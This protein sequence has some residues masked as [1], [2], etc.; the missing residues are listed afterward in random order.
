MEER[1]PSRRGLGRSE[2]WRSTR[3]WRTPS[4]CTLQQLGADRGG[5]HGPIGRLVRRGTTTRTDGTVDGP[6]EPHFLLQLGRGGEIP[7]PATAVWA[8]ADAQAANRAARCAGSGSRRGRAGARAQRV[9]RRLRLRGARGASPRRYLGE[10]ARET[11]RPGGIPAARRLASAR[12]CWGPV[13]FSTH[14]RCDPSVY[15][16]RRVNSILSSGASV[17]RETISTTPVAT[18]AVCERQRRQRARTCSGMSPRCRGWHSEP[19]SGYL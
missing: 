10:S 15:A 16:W 8:A 2:A 17:S 14:S 11:S 9:E 7:V 4:C 6:D 19:R 12:A 1:K 3:T 13:A 18:G 5:Q